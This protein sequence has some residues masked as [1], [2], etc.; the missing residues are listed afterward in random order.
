[1]LLIKFRFGDF[2]AFHREPDIQFWVF[3]TIF[4][5]FGIFSGFQWNFK[6]GL[7]PSLRGIISKQIGITIP[8]WY[9]SKVFIMKLWFYLFYTFSR[10]PNLEYWIFVTILANFS[11]FSIIFKNGPESS[12]KMPGNL[13]LVKTIPNINIIS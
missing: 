1:M 10:E 5:D 13:K 9:V 7:E 3:L 2:S 11:V 4:D 8:K 12:K 6:I